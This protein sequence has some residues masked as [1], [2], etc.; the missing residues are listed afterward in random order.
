MTSN[1]LIIKRTL[2]LSVFLG[3]HAFSLHQRGVV[4][5]RVGRV[6]FEMEDGRGIA[7]RRPFS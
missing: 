4:A 7:N 6:A 1:D 2:L 5:I 3:R